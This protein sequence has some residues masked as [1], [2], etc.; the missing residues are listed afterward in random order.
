M[1]NGKYSEFLN[2]LQ[3]VE[4]GVKDI[5]QEPRRPV[6]AVY[7]PIDAVFSLVASTEGED[8]VEVATMGTEGLV[9]L[10]MDDLERDLPPAR[11]LDV[12]P[13]HTDAAHKRAR[14]LFRKACQ[15]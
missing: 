6:Q 2:R 14:L 1:P 3:R 12:G 10:L 11:S 7:F 5:V 13:S 15:T 8:V 4:V 9:G